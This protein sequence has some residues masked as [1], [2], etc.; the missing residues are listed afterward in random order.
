MARNHIIELP[1]EIRDKIYEM[2]FECES[3]SP[4]GP[5]VK[6]GSPQPKGQFGDVKKG[7]Y[8]REYLCRGK[9]PLQHAY[10]EEL[11]ALLLVSRQ[12]SVEAKPIFYSN[13]MFT[14][15]LLNPTP[16]FSFIRGSGDEDRMNMIRTIEL[17]PYFSCIGRKWLISENDRSRLG[18]LQTLKGLRNL[19]FWTCKG[20][21]EEVERSLELGGIHTLF[22]HL[23]VSIELI[24]D[25]SRDQA[26]V[27]MTTRQLIESSRR[28]I[29]RDSYISTR[30]SGMTNW[31]RVHTGQKVL[32]K[33]DEESKQLKPGPDR[34]QEFGLFYGA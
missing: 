11:L 20:P 7:F 25:E 27:F 28:T 24:I 19:K 3:I 2:V 34:D 22:G 17:G 5:C 26:I 32:W 13:T 33:W 8:V 4:D 21:L 1:R 12:I 15:Y 16:F 30:S 31:N 18:S 29:V 6:P 14:G 9:M 23:S 10:T